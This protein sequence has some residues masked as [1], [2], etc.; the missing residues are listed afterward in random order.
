[1]PQWDDLRGKKI[2]GELYVRMWKLWLNNKKDRGK[3]GIMPKMQ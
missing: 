2:K 3:Y 1:M